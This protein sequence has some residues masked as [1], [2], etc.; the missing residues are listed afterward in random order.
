MNKTQLS[1]IPK[2][3]TLGNVFDRLSEEI[4]S[5]FDV[6]ASPFS[7]RSFFKGGL[8]S[9]LWDE[10]ENE[11]K[12]EIEIPRFTKEDI[13]LSIEDN[14]RFTNGFGSMLHINAEKDDKY[15]FYHSMSIPEAADIK[16]DPSV[17]LDHGILTI[18][19]RKKESAK[20]RIIEIK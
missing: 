19:F 1:L 6:F 17:T 14:A 13:K 9:E 2:S 11:F 16:H 18:S 20:P 3:T 4:W 15:R 12:T 10:S 7:N 5:N 8:S